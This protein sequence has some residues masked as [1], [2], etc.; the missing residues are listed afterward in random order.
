MFNEANTVE[1]ERNQYVVTTQYTFRAGATD[2]RADLVLLVNGIP[3]VV[4]EAPAASQPLDP[5]AAARRQR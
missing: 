2:K 3:L 4:I 5:P 1:V